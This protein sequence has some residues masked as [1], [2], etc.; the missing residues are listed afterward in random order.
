MTIFQFFPLYAVP[1][2][3]VTSA[4]QGYG[5]AEYQTEADAEYACKIMNGIKLFGKPLRI[6][7]ASSDRKQIDIGA[8]LFVGNLDAGVDERLLYDTFSAFG[9]VLGVPKVRDPDLL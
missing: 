9:R 8:N 7:K 2:D 3:R 5:F 6:N 4:H 1:K